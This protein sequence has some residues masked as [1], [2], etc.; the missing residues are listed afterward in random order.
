MGFPGVPI[1]CLLQCSLEAFSVWL[2]EG[3][4]EVLSQTERRFE[5]HICAG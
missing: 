4:N 5:S 2:M 1:E 3:L